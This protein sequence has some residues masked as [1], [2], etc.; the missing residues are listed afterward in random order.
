MHTLQWRRKD[1]RTH[2]SRSQARRCSRCHW[3]F[4]G[5]TQLLGPTSQRFPCLFFPSQWCRSS[6]PRHTSKWRSI[7]DLKKRLKTGYL[8]RI[9]ASANHLHVLESLLVRS[10]LHLVQILLRLSLQTVIHSN[11]VSISYRMKSNLLAYWGSSDLKRSES[12]GSRSASS[13]PS[14]NQ[15]RPSPEWKSP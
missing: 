2:T 5:W 4:W 11:V 9:A 3:S 13:R 15:N 14:P 7:R 12:Q 1:T 10:L 8:C 6:S